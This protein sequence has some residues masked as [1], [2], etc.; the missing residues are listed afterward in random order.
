MRPS[1]SFNSIIGYWGGAK[2]VEEQ[3]KLARL[4]MIHEH[5]RQGKHR[6]QLDEQ[7]E[8]RDC[9]ANLAAK[10]DREPW[11]LELQALKSRSLDQLS[12]EEKA[13]LVELTRRAPGA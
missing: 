2:G 5:V 10:L 9:L 6:F 8:F 7:A 12:V 13:R 11:L 3:Q 4:I 1:S